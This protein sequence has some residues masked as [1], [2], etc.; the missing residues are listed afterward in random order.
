MNSVKKILLIE[1]D[2]LIQKL[3]RELLKKHGFDTISTSSA[4]DA[5]EILNK[6]KFDIVITDIN[7]PDMNG[8][9][10]LLWMNKNNI[11]SKLIAITS[12]LSDKMKENFLKNGAIKYLTKP[13]NFDNLVKIIESIYKEGFSSQVDNLELFDYLKIE[14]LSKKNKLVSI[15]PNLSNE[16]AYIFFKNGNI[17]N[18]EYKNK[19]GLEA[20]NEI[21]LIKGGNIQEEAWKEPDNITISQPLESLLINSATILDEIKKDYSYKVLLVDDSDLSRKIISTF[22]VKNGI[23]VVEVGSALKAV[24]LVKKIDFDIIISDIFMPEINGFEF[25]L[26]LK[27]NEIKSKVIMITANNLDEYK[28]FSLSNGAVEYYNKAE[29]LSYL[30]NCINKDRELGFKGKVDDIHVFDYIQVASLSRKDIRLDLKFPLEDAKGSVYLKKGKVIHSKYN[31]LTA[32]DAFYKIISMKNGIISE[33][34]FDYHVAESI[35]ISN[36]KLFMNSA[37]YIAS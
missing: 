6:E 9:E 29:N 11:N 24:E 22:L 27:K 12:I 37:N 16:T 2:L 33:H 10:L 32:E 1:D 20:F 18:A 4:I 5:M 28:S 8:F 25:L 13:V 26:W 34:S 19:K 7:M 17:I 35:N 3:M 30:L 21:I 15:K 14:A 31:E 36:F 23:H